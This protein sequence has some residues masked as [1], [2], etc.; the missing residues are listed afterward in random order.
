VR[1]PPHVLR[2]YALIADGE[3]GALIG[4]RGDISWL[5]FP[6]WA[7]PAVMASLLGGGGVYAVQPEE[8]RFVWGGSYEP[9]TLIWRSRWVVGEAIVE[10]R[11]A[12]AFPGETD[13]LVLL[14]RIEGVSGAAR[15]AVTFELACDYGRAPARDVHRDEDGAWHGRAGDAAFR[16]TGAAGARPDPEGGMR[17]E[18]DIAEGGSHDL[19]LVLGAPGELPE[20]E[21]RRAWEAT[22]AA[23]RDACPPVECEVAARDAHHARAVLRGLTSVH[24]GMVAAATMSLPER[25]GAGRN[26]D[27]RF[28]WLRDQALAGHAAVKAGATDLLDSAVCFLRDRLL[29]DGDQVVPAYTVGGDH[30]P[31]EVSLGLPGYPGGADIAGNH[32]N[33]QFQLDVFGEALLLF[34]AAAKVD[35][36][37]ADTVRAAQLAAMAIEHRAAEKDAGIW[38]LDP[39]HWTHS[40][41]IC[42]AGLRAAAPM[43]RSTGDPAALAAALVDGAAVHPSGRWQRAVEDPRVDAALLF[44]AV[45]GAT[46]PED[47]RAVATLEAVLGEL[48]QDDY[49][50]R[51]R[52]DD[53]PLGEAEGAF[54]LCGLLTALALH[55]QGRALEAARFF[56]RNRAACG[57]PGLLTEEFD[58]RQRQLRGNLPQAFVHALLL[59]CAATTGDPD[60]VH[61]T[62]AQLT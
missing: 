3:R 49:V 53:R 28:A 35:R 38:E 37:D 36:V 10:C 16:W 48:S 55:Q 7:D 26:Y 2:E 47:P 57:P 40:R 44:A 60:A 41:L 15:M 61:D 43:L 22:T 14:R 25:A 59:E 18:F 11:E 32:A 8:D 58:V 29:A 17:L 13:R 27:Y 6:G 30:V 21:P 39:A 34:A 19:V 1:F 42:A 31:D 5:C 12:L 51:Y 45:R 52:P 46:P 20:I 54:L 9:G 33:A 23:W 4:P 56:E 24:G 62:E 50:Y